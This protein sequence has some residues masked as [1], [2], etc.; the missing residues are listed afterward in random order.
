MEFVR[1]KEQT[2]SS[3]QRHLVSSQRKVEPYHPHR[4]STERSISSG[5]TQHIATALVCNPRFA[6]A[7]LNLVSDILLNCT[8][9]LNKRN[10]V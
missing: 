9:W 1:F 7:G 3:Q 2:N 10:N 6:N 8:K 5:E 4:N